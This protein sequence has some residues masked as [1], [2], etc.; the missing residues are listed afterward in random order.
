MIDFSNI[1]SDAKLT[2]YSKK[3]SI[4][5]KSHEIFNPFFWCD[6]FFEFSTF[7]Q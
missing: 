3:M 2:G 6:F 5:G 7:H 4:T 1:I